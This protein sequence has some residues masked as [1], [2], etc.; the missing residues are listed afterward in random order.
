MHLKKL[1]LFD[2]KNYEEA[3]FSFDNKVNCFL[4]KNGVGKTNILDAIYYL[5]F[6]KSALNGA[7]AQNVRHGKNQFT[8]KGDFEIKDS[9]A[10]VACTYT[11]GSKKTIR[12]DGNESR[13][14]SDHIGRYP[15]VLVAPNDIEL[16]WGGAELRRRF[17]DSLISQLDKHYLEHLIV[18]NNQLKQRNSLLRLSSEGRLDY[19]LL[20][21]YDQKLVESGNYIH[22]K[23]AEFLSSFLPLFER[24]YGFISGEPV[25]EVNI[26]YKSDCTGQDFGTLLKESRKRD[27]V[28]QRTS[29]GI[30]RDDF[31]FFLGGYELRKI[32]SQ[33][34]QKSFLI[35]LKLAEFQSIETVMKRKPLLLLDDI[36]DKLDDE[37]IHKLVTLV[38]NGTFGQLFITDAR[39]DRSQGL[40]KEANV[41]SELFMI[42]NGKPMEV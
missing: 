31:V 30:H 7:D 18:Y 16:I 37:R 23:R 36:F 9:V 28:I 26:A 21:T 34:Q 1:D 3:H 15:L 27:S 10:E 5:G 6:T 25:E 33:G 39:P 35:G 2:F 22:Q 38:V 29:V 11:L 13:K 32:G 41:Q 17:F 8:I 12:E 24:H 20:D 14:M 19:D 42:E 4:G 40:L